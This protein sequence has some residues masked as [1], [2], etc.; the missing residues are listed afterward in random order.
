MEEITEKCVAVDNPTVG[1]PVEAMV[2]EPE[3]KPLVECVDCCVY[4]CVWLTKQDEMISF[5]QIEHKHQPEEDMPPNN[6]RR[7]K[8]YI[9]MT[10]HIQAVQVQKGVRHK[11]PNCV[12]IG[13]RTQA[14][15]IPN[16]H[17]SQV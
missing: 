6:I 15:S 5:D 8:L 10:L 1:L 4:P 14:V 12:E 17:G 9:Q 11:L 2:E 16:L 7:K 13:T 3:D